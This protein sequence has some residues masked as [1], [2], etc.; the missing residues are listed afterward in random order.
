[1]IARRDTAAQEAYATGLLQHLASMCEETRRNASSDPARIE[2]MLQ[3]FEETLATLA[4][5]F[6]RLGETPDFSRDAIL[7][8]AQHASSS[9]QAL[10][11]AMSLELDRLGRAIVESDRGAHATNAYAHAQQGTVRQGLDF[12]G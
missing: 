12:L 11:E 1:M 7:S 10:M 8:A 6:E 9:H 3:S 4:P 2:T 5:I